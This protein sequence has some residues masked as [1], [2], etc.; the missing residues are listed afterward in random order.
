LLK[1]DINSE[2]IKQVKKVATDLL[3]EVKSEL[4]R[5]HDWYKFENTRAEVKVYIHNKLW[6]D[7]QGFP[8]SYSQEEVETKVDA[9][10]T[11][12]LDKYHTSEPFWMGMAG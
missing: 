4:N 5:I 12:F 6:D 11:H 8:P 2:D 10:F 3:T 7:K 1:P 9:L